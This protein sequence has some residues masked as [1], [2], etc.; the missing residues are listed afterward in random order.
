MT[1][2]NQRNMRI[3]D[4]QVATGGL[5]MPDKMIRL[6]LDDAKDMLFL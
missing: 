3:L 6:Q 2:L 1:T 5:L 4:A